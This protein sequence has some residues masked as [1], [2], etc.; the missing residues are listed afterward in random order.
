MLIAV[1]SD[2]HG[3]TEPMCRAVEAHRPDMVLHLGDLVRDAEALARSFPGLD[4][5]FVCGNCDAWDPSG[6]PER[7]IFPAEGVT[8][9][10][11]H[12]HR[13][14]VKTALE[15]LA[16][17]VHFSGAQLGLFGHTHQAEFRK[18][19]DVTLFNPGSAGMGR[20]SGGLI[21]VKGEQFKCRLIDL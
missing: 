14:S 8:I 7:L 16:N 1:F 10:M 3:N 5:R 17:A 15:P 2:S 19:G 11:E 21:E 20:Y 6:A 18:M 12:G 13:H 9:Y 4:V